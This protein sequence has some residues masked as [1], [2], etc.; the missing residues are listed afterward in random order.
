MPLNDAVAGRSLPDAELMGRLALTAGMP[1]GVV[2]SQLGQRT[3][4]HSAWVMRVLLGTGMVDSS[5]IRTFHCRQL[6]TSPACTLGF[7]RSQVPQQLGELPAK[8]RPL[9]FPANARR[10]CFDLV[11]VLPLLPPVGRSTGVLLGR[12][13]GFRLR[14]H[15]AALRRGN[16]AQLLLAFGLR[17]CESLARC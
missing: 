6:L 9:Q 4:R 1:Q 7:N 12:R 14:F 3:G 10:R 16:A 5:L 15:T 17:L 2:P 11:L 13:Q 8:D